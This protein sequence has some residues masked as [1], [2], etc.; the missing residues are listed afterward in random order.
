M[1]LSSSHQPKSRKGLLRVGVI[2]LL[3]LGAAPATA[4]VLIRNFMTVDVVRAEPCLKTVAGLDT[5]GYPTGVPSF[6]MTSDTVATPQGVPLLRQVITFR[7]VKPE[8]TL[9]ADPIRIRNRCNRPLTIQL[10]AEAH[11]TSA[12]AVDG[13]WKDLSARAYLSVGT[14]ASPAT[15][16]LPPNPAGAPIAGG[17]SFADP[18]VTAL[19]NQTPIRVTA[20]A[21]GVGTLATAATGSVSLPANQD[22]QIALVIDAGSTALATDATLRLVVKALG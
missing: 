20:S 11:S 15:D 2:A 14:A 17:N 21:G 3:A 5:I 18:T 9:S 19:W 22:V 1:T 10:V 12:L 4:A 13:E 6:V 16:A 8:R 7:G